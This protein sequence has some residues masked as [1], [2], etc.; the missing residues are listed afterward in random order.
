MAHAIQYQETNNT[1]KMGIKPEQTCFQTRYTDG[2]HAHEKMFNSSNHQGMP[3]K[4]TM[5]YHL[6]LFRMSKGLQIAHVGKDVKK[7]SLVHCCWEHKLVQPLQKIVQHLLKNLKIE[8]SYNPIF[9]FL[10]LY[11][12]NKNTNS[13][14]NIHLSIHKSTIYNSHDMEAPSIPKPMKE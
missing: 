12:K 4:N 9:L 5:R 7:G 6:I 11:Q 2:Q 8:L 10:E 1:I 14:R 13:K 3:I